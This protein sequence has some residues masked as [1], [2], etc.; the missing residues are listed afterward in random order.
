MTTAPQRERLPN[1][2][3]NTSF[4]FEVGGLG[5]V[6]TVSRFPDGR[7]AEIFLENHKCDSQAGANARDSAVV[8]SL[9]LQHGVDLQT[10]RHT[11]LRDPRGK[12]ATPLG[13]ALDIIASEDTG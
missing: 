8:C 6:A 2:R 5:Y 13:A 1:R 7:V 3:G 10:I 12:P 11:L 4:N 9:A